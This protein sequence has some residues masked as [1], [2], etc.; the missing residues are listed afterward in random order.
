VHEAENLVAVVDVLDDDAKAVDVDDVAQHPLFLRHLLI[1]A[2]QVLLAAED[3]ADDVLFRERPFEFLG[4]LLHH[5]PLVAATTAQRAIEYPVS[6]R[7]QVSEPEILEH[8][9]E[10]IDTEAVR[11]WRV[12][13]ER[14]TRDALALLRRHRIEGLHVVKAV[15][16]LDED[17]TNV[18]DHCQHHLAKALGLGFRP[19][20]ELDLVELAD[21]VDE[22]GNLRAELLL[23]LLERCLGVLDDVVQYRGCDCLRVHVHV[24]KLLRHGDRVRNIRFTGLAGLP[25]VCGGAE[26]ISAHDRRDLLLGE[27]GFE[28]FDQLPQAVVAPRRARQLG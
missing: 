10:A 9:L 14:F 7:V 8:H 15:G 23:D 24:R 2:V 25:I 18:L 16:Q 28:R 5:L 4:D 19:A 3:L 26:F 17:D 6:H 11:D 22:P 1:D 21:A 27:V 12:D 20:A 13:I